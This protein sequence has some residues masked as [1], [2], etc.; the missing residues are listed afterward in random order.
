MS[1][2]EETLALR[3]ELGRLVAGYRTSLAL[4]AAARLGIAD[5]LAAGPRSAEGVAEA[6][7]TRAASL[8]RLL[9]MLAGLGLVEE[10][11]GA[12]ALTPMGVFLRSDVPGSARDGIVVT[13]EIELA[14]WQRLADGMRTGQTPFELAHGAALFEY[15]GQ[16]QHVDLARRFDRFMSGATTGQANAL[17]RA[18]DLA[19]FGVLV[20]VGGGD[21]TLLSVLLRA[22]SHLRGVLFDLPNVV[23]AARTKLDAAGLHERCATVGGSFFDA[24]PS[25]GDLYLLKWILHDWEDEDCVR[26]LANCRRVIA[27]TG[28]LLLFELV[29]PS[30]AAGNADRFALAASA[31]VHMFAVTG[32][33]ERT[34]RELGALLQRGGFA[35]TRVRPTEIAV[36]LVEATPA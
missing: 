6:T 10:R 1:I 5:A 13:C 19:P 16:P 32:G 3:Q 7:G 29:V 15:L 30:S 11:D 14:A 21:G 2:S 23:D 27:P 17:L 22:H 31:D 34:E 36:S 4:Y 26:I 24:V 33:R 35:L 25:G 8:A 9:R 28:R 20:D 18:F 12:Y